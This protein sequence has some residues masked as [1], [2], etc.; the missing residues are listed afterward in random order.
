[1]EVREQRVDPRGS[2]RPGARKSS[3]VPACATTRPCAS[4]QL[5]STR[6]VVVPTATTRDPRA[7]RV[8]DRRRRRLRQLIALRVQAAGAQRRV[9]ERRERAA[10]H[11]Q[12][13]LGALDAARR[14]R[15]EQCVGEVQARG[16]RGHR[17]RCARE[18]RL[19]ALRILGA[20]RLAVM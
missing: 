1:V 6:A 8:A 14:E 20:R 2:G 13:H 4:A 3:V 18:H 11:V 9:A 12:H 10:P 5:S 16:R 15:C 7:A 17:A 19:V